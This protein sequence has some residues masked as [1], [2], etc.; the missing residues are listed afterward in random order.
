MTANVTIDA[1][2]KKPGRR[3][4][5]AKRL[6]SELEF[7]PAMLEVL[8]TPPRPA[9]R[10]IVATICSFFAVALTWSIVGQID[11]VAVAQGQL[12]T[13]E[14]VKLVQPLEP[15]IVRAI[16][17]RDG[18]RVTH[19]DILIELDP[20]EAQANV[21]SLRY[22]LVKGRL[23]AAAA[24]AILT[25]DPTIAFVSPDGAE[26]H[27]VE[28]TR[29]Q[30]LGEWEK[31][32]ATLASIEADIEDEEAAIAS[33]DLQ[34]KK[35]SETL[36]I[37]EE[38]LSVLEELNEKGL[39]RKPDLLQ[40]RQ[41]LI[42]MK[43]ERES[44]KALQVQGQA[45]LD[46]RDRKR[47]ETVAAFRA[48][49]LQKRAE[50]LRK[51]AS[52]EQQILKEE[53]RSEDRKLRAS[54]DGIV[55]GLSVFTTGGVVTTKDT[56]LRIVPDGSRLEAEIVILNRD[57][58]FVTEGQS[59][60]LKLE[61]FPFTRYGLIAGEVL[62]IWHDAV[63]DEKQGLVF[64]ATVA[65]KSDKILVGDRWVPLAP[66]MQVQAEVKTGERRIISY[67]LSPLLRYRDESLRER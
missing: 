3:V 53:R 61:A 65:L 51:I 29:L 18:Q 38:R 55:F 67:F 34:M 11:T 9:A 19:G 66:G 25:E 40:L 33:L 58:G 6:P 45:K 30:M 39:A 42:E 10:M 60:E 28:A 56:L 23:E 17:V 4:R 57:I 49:N 16:H 15:S 12:V 22:D 62:Q 44:N 20:T 31:Q 63:P 8:E 32:A 26:P 48:E 54:V 2:A 13:T 21:N 46:A 52:L 1:N 5:A 27:L 36:P 50:A 14:R 7:L 37:L 59:T 41:S 24:A 47:Q 35:L 43:A 64:K